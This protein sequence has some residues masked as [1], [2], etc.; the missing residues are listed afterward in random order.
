MAQIELTVTGPRDDSPRR[1]L[2][3]YFG[4]DREICQERD[5]W[6]PPSPRLINVLLL[7]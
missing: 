6:L 2:A 1:P 3:P 7:N 5:D 4:R